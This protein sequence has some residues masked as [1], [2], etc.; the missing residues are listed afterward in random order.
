[1][2]DRWSKDYSSNSFWTQP[3]DVAGVSNSSK[4]PRA[5]P[6]SVVRNLKRA[7]KVIQQ[8]GSVI[9]IDYGQTEFDGFMGKIEQIVTLRN[10]KANFQVPSD[11]PT[12]IDEN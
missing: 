2:Q 3:L 6:V 9:S 5:K 8:I 4:S 11:L 10:M 7:H 12:D 1:M